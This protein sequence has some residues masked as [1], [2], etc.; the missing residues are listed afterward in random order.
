[1]RA[2]RQE[3]DCVTLDMSPGGIA[4]GAEAT[5]A[6]GERIVAY[7]NQVGR[8]EGTVARVFSGGF[9]IQTRLTAAKRDR[10]ADQLT[11]L[12]NRTSLR[13]PEDRRHERLIP[14][15]PRTVLRLSNGKE[16]PAI[17]AD[18]SVS[19]AAVRVDIRPALGSRVIIG[20]TLA[21]VVRHLEDGIAIEFAR[22][23]RPDDFGP[24]IVL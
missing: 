14:R 12:A 17:L 2:D 10:L 23:I 5:V 19:G 20:S 1:M 22:P 16:H 3:F 4:F 15:D 9:A 8:V 6:P 24:D 13:L 21:Q 18:I 7:L 11:W